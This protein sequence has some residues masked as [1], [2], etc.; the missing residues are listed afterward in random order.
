MTVFNSKKLGALTMGVLLL[1]QPALVSAAD[2]NRWPLIEDRPGEKGFLRIFNGKDLT[3][4]NGDPKLWSVK[5]GAITG[6]TT[7]DNPT[8]GNT[9][10]IWTNGTVADFELRCS[11]KLRP[12]D[13]KGFANSGIQYRSKVFDPTNWVVGGYQADMEAGP[14]Y[15]GILYEER[16]RGILALRG[17]KVLLDKEG[18][19]QVVGSVG[20]GAEIGAAIKTGDWN[21]YVIIAKGN[22]LQH[23]ING[24]QAVDV[25]DEDE[26]KRAL[27]GV[28]ALQ[29]HAGPPMM[30]QFKNLRI[31]KL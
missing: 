8:K 1:A 25:V 4:W 29:L 24:K 28:L 13:A 27:S 18:K 11:F 16:M 10:L 17:Q 26:A 3:G 23:I 19:K 31:R 15:T 6:Q 9:F 12:G 21:E 22:R 30:A 20:A 5:D 2:A 14:D 7:A